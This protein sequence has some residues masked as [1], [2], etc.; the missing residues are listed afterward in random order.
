MSE[1]SLNV[2]LFLNTKEDNIHGGV[3]SIFFIPSVRL[4]GNAPFPKIFSP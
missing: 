4:N 3:S 1:R 2:S